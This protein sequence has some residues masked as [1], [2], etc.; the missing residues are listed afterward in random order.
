MGVVDGTNTVQFSK[1][2]NST[3]KPRMNML[4]ISVRKRNKETNGSYE[5][6][7]IASVPFYCMLTSTIEKEVSEMLAVFT[8]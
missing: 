6:R 1:K 5:F 3:E 4:L 8:F 7:S 2:K